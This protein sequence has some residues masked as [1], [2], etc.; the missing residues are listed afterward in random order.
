MYLFTIDLNRTQDETDFVYSTN[1][2]NFIGTL[3]AIYEKSI[4]EGNKIPDIEPNILSDLFKSNKNEAFIKSPIKSKERPKPIDPNQKGQIPDENRW[5]WELYIDLEE[6]IKNA[7]K[8]LDE[9]LEKFRE[10]KT[11]LMIKPDEYVREIEIEENQREVEEIKQEIYSVRNQR[12]ELE[13]KMPEC[14]V[15][16]LF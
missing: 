13:A 1:P 10:F 9:Y 15:L 5:V 11:I 6:A 7:I 4:E 8:P 2:Q 16:S 14:V 3:L 12:K